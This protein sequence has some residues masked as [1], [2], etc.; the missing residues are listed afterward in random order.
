MSIK[1]QVRELADTI[2]KE[3]K[4][5]KATGVATVGEDLYTRTLPEGID[6]DV[7]TKIQEHNTAFAAAGLLALGEA[8]IPVMKKNKE[9]AGAELSVPTVGKDSFSFTFDRSRQV[10]DGNGGTKESFGTSGVKFNMYGAGSRGEG[11]KVKA[12]LS[13][14]AL[15]SFGS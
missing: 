15:A 8:A 14:Q 9:L 11:K 10:P 12:E 13:E 6:A 1:Y 2:A 4:I 5:D 3:I 7:I